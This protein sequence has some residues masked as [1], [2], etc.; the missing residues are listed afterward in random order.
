ME[1]LRLIG[2]SDH[3]L[4]CAEFF[5]K[6]WISFN[7]IDDGCLSW[8]TVRIISSEPVKMSTRSLGN[9]HLCSAEIFFSFCS[10]NLILSVASIE[11]MRIEMCFVSTWKNDQRLLEWLR[12]MHTKWIERKTV[13]VKNERRRLV[14]NCTDIS[15]QKDRL[16]RMKATKDSIDVG[17]WIR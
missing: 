4:R 3:C 16:I 9:I 2:F 8:Y 12:K 1:N 7:W 10:T 13:F 17:I 14:N 11:D 5:V 6:W 15:G